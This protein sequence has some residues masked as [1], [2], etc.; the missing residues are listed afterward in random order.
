MD[1]IYAVRPSLY[2]EM[3]Q[4]GPPP[5]SMFGRRLCVPPPLTQRPVSTATEFE[6]DDEVDLTT[7]TPASLTY[8]SDS[9]TTSSSVDELPTPFTAGLG[10][11]PFIIDDSPVQ[12]P[13]GPH[14]FRTSSRDSDHEVLSLSPITLSKEQRK[15]SPR[16]HIE[17]RCQLDERQ[18]HNWS[19][20][21]VAEWMTEAGFDSAVANKFAFHKIDGSTL[22]DLELEDLKEIEISAFG[23][24]KRL[25]SSIHHLRQ[26]CAIDPEA[27]PIAGI[28]AVKRGLSRPTRLGETHVSVRSSHSQRNRKA[29]S[30]D[31][32]PAES[33]SI[34]AIEQL[35]P[36][37]HSCERCESGD[38]QNCRAWRKQQ[39][40]IQKTIA[41]FEQE[42]ATSAPLA[43]PTGPSVIGSSDVLG[44]YS[45]IPIT[46]EIL[47]DV[48][49]RDPMDHVKQF[50]K[51]QHV[52]SPRLLPPSC[53]TAEIT[54]VAKSERTQ[55][56]LLGLPRLTIPS[57]VNEQDSPDRTPILA[58]GILNAVQVQSKTALRDDP[59]HYGGVASPVDVYRLDTPASLTDLP[60]TAIPIDPCHREVSRSVPPQIKYGTRSPSGHS[61]LRRSTSAIGVCRQPSF[62]PT[63]GS[64]AEDPISTPTPRA[65]LTQ[66][67][68]LVKQ[69]GWMRK[70]IATRLLRH[71]WQDKYF[72]LE[73]NRLEMFEAG[74]RAHHLDSINMDDY[75]VR[76]QSTVSNSKLQAAFKRI[77]ASS[78]QP[79]FA[80]SLIP[81]TQKSR[82]VFEKSRGHHFAV[83]SEQE[84]KDWIRN[85]MLASKITSKK[86]RSPA[87]I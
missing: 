47:S 72:D 14:L 85:L 6:I 71:E 68:K 20:S 22:L 38:P 7:L 52:N 60:I 39:R 56:N 49:L 61:P 59:Y 1:S 74:S 79:E 17:P 33:I 23:H 87:M 84:H 46:A 44:P 19:S 86:D 69:T 4:K 62:K 51:F 45:S 15:E 50:L 54:S 24:R 78:P 77:G 25:M 63:I 28:S 35:L 41:A 82:K 11:F 40:K 57:H 42:I 80:I 2:G 30:D 58:T 18:V 34:V 55:H 36:E 70:R 3:S 83:N 29:R 64:L 76:A 53:S 67:H 5:M 13:V 73:G 43:S 27:T 31:I 81:E 12:G 8:D 26:S 48:G 75:V 21:Q 32:T 37:A 16:L 65:S 10:G 66:E 9:P